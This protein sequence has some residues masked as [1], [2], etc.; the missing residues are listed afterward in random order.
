MPLSL[1]K[2]STSGEPDTPSMPSGDHPPVAVLLLSDPDVAATIQRLLQSSPLRARLS[3]VGTLGD[4]MIAASNHPPALAIIDAGLCE[5][6]ER[7]FLDHLLRT[8]SGTQ[9]LLLHGDMDERWPP[10]PR[11]T[12]VVPQAVLPAVV[13]WLASRAGIGETGA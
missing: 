6:L 3:Q 7:E 8:H 11:L 1:P 13:L 2:C 5:A 9:V 12:H 4:A 10:Q